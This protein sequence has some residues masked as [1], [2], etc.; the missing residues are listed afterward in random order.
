M[1]DPQREL[2][3]LQQKVRTLDIQAELARS[4][5]Y[6]AAL[7]LFNPTTANYGT[8]KHYAQQLMQEDATAK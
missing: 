5:Q 7:F 3:Y 4:F 6:A 1:S 2:A 8:L